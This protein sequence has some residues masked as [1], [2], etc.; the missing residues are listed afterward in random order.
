MSTIKAVV[1]AS[2]EELVEAHKQFNKWAI[3]NPSLGKSS[4]YS[5]AFRHFSKRKRVI[6]ARFSTLQSKKAYAMVIATTYV[7]NG[8]VYWRQ[9]DDP[10][11][12]STARQPPPRPRNE[13]AAIRVLYSKDMAAMYRYV[14]CK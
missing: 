2:E 12:K 9:H 11:W 14:L 10:G 7:A 6:T 13:G 1:R 8:K 3:D 4:I 5:R